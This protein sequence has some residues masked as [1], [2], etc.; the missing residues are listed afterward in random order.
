MNNDDDKDTNPINYLDD[1]NEAGNNTDIE[2]DNTEKE[3]IMLKL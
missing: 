1:E 2:D 3:A